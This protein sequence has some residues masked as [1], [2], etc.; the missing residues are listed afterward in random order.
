MVINGLVAATLG[1]AGKAIGAF[2]GP[3]LTAAIT[4]VGAVAISTG[5]VRV[6]RIV[7]RVA[8]ALIDVV[9]VDSLEA[10]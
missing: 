2:A 8:S 1:Q 5:C 3:E 9:A 7:A 4:C 6:A 10:I